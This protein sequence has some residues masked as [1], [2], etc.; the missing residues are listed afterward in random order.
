VGVGDVGE[1]RVKV[2]REE[3]EVNDFMTLN[4]TASSWEPME[5]RLVGQ[6][7]EVMLGGVNNTDCSNIPPGKTVPSPSDPGEPCLKP[8]GQE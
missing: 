4:G 1:K 8:P 6:V 7:E 5:L 2:D 3:K